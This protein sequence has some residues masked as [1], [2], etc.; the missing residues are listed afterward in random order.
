MLVM[1]ENNIQM[2]EN[3]SSS[4]AKN[5]TKSPHGSFE[6]AITKLLKSFPGISDETVHKFE[7]EL[8]SI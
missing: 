6:T 7:L 8:K 2:Q 4:Q 5:E 1:T 3:E